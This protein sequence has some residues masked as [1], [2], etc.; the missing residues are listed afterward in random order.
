VAEDII[1][2]CHRTDLLN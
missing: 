2:S 1:S